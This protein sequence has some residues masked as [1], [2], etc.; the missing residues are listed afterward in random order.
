M[1]RHSLHARL[2]ALEARRPPACPACGDG[3][4]F[5]WEFVRDDEPDPFPVCRAC[6]RPVPLR[7]IRLVGVD[8]QA[9]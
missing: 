5:L 2:S 1:P 7:V 9:V 8:A 6:G 4:R 3:T